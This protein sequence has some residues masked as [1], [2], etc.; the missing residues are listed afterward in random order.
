MSKTT[1]KSEPQQTKA[2][3]PVDEVKGSIAKMSDQFRLALPPH[4][5]VERFVRVTQT[6]IS[7]SPD[8]IAADRTSLF[9]AA[10]KAAQEGLLPDGKEAAI[11]TFNAN[12][13]NKANPKWIKKAQYM[14]MVAGILKKVRNSGELSMI[15]SNVI[16]KND[17]FRYWVD[18]EGEHL[19]HEPNLFGDR[20]DRIGVYSLARTKDGA[21]YID[22]MRTEEVEAARNVSRAKDSGP[23]S[24]PFE[25]EMWKKTSIKRLAKRLPMS[26]DLE[27]TIRSDDEIFNPP[28]NPE[29]DET[30]EAKPAKTQSSRLSK[31]MGLG[32]DQQAGGSEVIETEAKDV[33]ENDTPQGAE[34]TGDHP[35][36]EQDVPI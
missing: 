33:S 18:Q 34:T 21:V 30:R 4:I 13:G 16:F 9:A 25:N 1:P 26:T 5:P 27:M 23:W 14:P 20:G 22:V 6:A 15:T 17:Q 28:E 19:T 10:M 8:L 3:A 12:I 31:A 24:G 2:L 32:Q 11:V 7:T 29:Q 35:I 36:S